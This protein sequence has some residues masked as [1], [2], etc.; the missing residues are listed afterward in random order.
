MGTKKGMHHQETSIKDLWT[1]PK[2]GKI[3]IGGRGVWGGGGWC[4]ESEYMCA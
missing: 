3:E 2:V 1:M 4:R